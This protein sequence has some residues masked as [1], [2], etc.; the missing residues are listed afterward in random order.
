MITP[1]CSLLLQEEK[2]GAFMSLNL[3]VEPNTPPLSR[4]EFCAT[5]RGPAIALDGYVYGGPFFEEKGPY[6]NFNHHERVDRLATRATCGQVMLAICQ[7]LF[8]ILT[9]DDG[10]LHGDVYMNDCDEDC[11]T[12]WTL[13]KHGQK[14]LSL[15]DAQDPESQVMLTRLNR[16]V[17]KEDLLDATAGAYCFRPEMPIIQKIAWIFK[18]YRQFRIAGGTREQRDEQHF[19][20]VIEKVENRILQ[21][22]EGNGKSITLNTIYER[23]GG[24]KN[25][26]MVHEIGL[27]ARTGMFVDGIRAYVSVRQRANGRYDYT[28][29]RMSPFVKFPIP[30]F[31]SYFNKI[32]MCGEDRWGGSH[33]CIG[34]PLIGGSA[35]APQSIQK[36][37]NRIVG[38][39]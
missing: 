18:P 17:W 39:I 10:Q 6:I 15:L 5:R 11:C 22:I 20:E 26:I 34:S 38:R 31:K 1:I 9:T 33:I 16:L 36:E 32:E 29:A 2:K 35:L 25:W 14:I 4:K 3:I 21:Y 7:G 13:L 37:I 12:S 30:K 8:Q 23:I 19:R 27:H 24:G 28:I